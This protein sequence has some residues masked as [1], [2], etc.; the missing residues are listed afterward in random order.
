MGF[1]LKGVAF[2]LSGDF[3]NS[4]E[5]AAFLLTRNHARQKTS[6]KTIHVS[7]DVLERIA[8]DV[9]QGGH[10]IFAPRDDLFDIGE[11]Q[12]TAAQGIPE[13]AFSLAARAMT[14]SA[15]LTVDRSAIARGEERFFLPGVLEN[16][17]KDDE[18]AAQDEERD[19]DPLSQV[20]AV[21]SVLV[22]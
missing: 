17:Q 14:D 20:R 2:T 22:A 1:P 3:F 13:S 21:P 16:E 4:P 12:I 8:L 7:R 5:S 10:F 15:G 11:R 9:R 6:R 18:R 19:D